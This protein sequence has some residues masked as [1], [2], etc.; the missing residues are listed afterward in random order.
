[1]LASLFVIPCF[2]FISL[3]TNG[4]LTA[5]Y[6]VAMMSLGGVNTWFYDN[7]NLHKRM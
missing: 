7:F 2:Y 4:A 1:M 6:I 5:T 3:L